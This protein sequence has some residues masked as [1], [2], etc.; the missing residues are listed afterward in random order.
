MKPWTPAA[1]EPL[2]RSEV[3]VVRDFS[4]TALGSLIREPDGQVVAKDESYR[5]IGRFDGRKTVD[6][7]GRPLMPGD[8]TKTLVLEAAA[9]RGKR[10]F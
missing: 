5:T 1:P 7:L 6:E 8:I 3:E 4:G 2:R 9:K 10:R